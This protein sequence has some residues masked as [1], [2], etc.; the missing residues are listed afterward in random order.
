[1]I[2]LIVSVTA[3]LSSPLAEIRISER[4]VP[5][6]K[7]TPGLD[8]PEEGLVHAGGPLLQAA[9]FGVTVE[10]TFEDGLLGEDGGDLFPAG[11]VVPKGEVH[12][13][14]GGGPVGMVRFDPAVVDG[15]F[16]EVGEDREREPG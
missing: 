8:F 9:R 14:G 16:L 12:D 6:E 2:R 13:T 7:I 10:G 5:G 3:V 1:M 4:D 11:G 15:E